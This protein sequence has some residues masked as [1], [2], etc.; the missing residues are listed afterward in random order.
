MGLPVGDAVKG[1]VSM[2]LVAGLGVSDDDVDALHIQVDG[3]RRQNCKIVKLEKKLKNCKHT[4]NTLVISIPVR[5]TPTT[6]TAK[7]RINFHE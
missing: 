2:V 7:S 1:E 4:T 3:E 5:K 6:G